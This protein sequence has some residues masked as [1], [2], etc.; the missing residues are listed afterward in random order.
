MT[1]PYF[2]GIW[3][4]GFGTFPLRGDVLKEALNT[5]LDIG[6][7]AIDTAQMYQNEPDIG[8]V[9]AHAGL[10]REEMLITSKVP[11]SNF[12]QD[13]FVPP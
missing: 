12:T 3:Q 10:P 2:K 13:T 9:L 8:D 4:R 5:A 1:S 6:Y 11:N 7:R